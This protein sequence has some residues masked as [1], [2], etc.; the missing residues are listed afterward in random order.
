MR[1]IYYR[2]NGLSEVPAWGAMVQIWREDDLTMGYV[3]APDGEPPSA[4]DGADMTLFRAGVI[5]AQHDLLGVFVWLEDESL[6]LDEWG[7][8]VL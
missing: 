7:E 5:R 3:S 6:W 8:L 4:P 1:E 2:V